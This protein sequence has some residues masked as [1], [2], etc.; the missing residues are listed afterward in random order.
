M[1]AIHGLQIGLR[2]PVAVVEDDDVRRGQVDSQSS[3]AC[4]EQENEFFAAGF[5]VLVDGA[6]TV[7][8]SCASVDTA[9]F[10]VVKGIV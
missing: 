6:Y 7:F 8:V 1:R 9:V 10:C 4:S 5:V 3:S 2:I